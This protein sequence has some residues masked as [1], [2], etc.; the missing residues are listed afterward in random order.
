MATA[1]NTAVVTFPVMGADVT[2]SHYGLATALS[3]GVTILITALVDGI[4]NPT[5]V[6]IVA[7]RAPEFAVG[8]LDL[9]LLQGD[10]EA[11]GA[12]HFLEEGL[13][14]LYLM[15]FMDA[16][17]E[18]TTSGYARQELNLADWTRTE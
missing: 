8:E 10:F 1:T 9:E 11:A 13:G 7:G 15:L 16:N 4:D 3:G 14:A 18:V 2:V 6:V 17:T 5:T 12:L